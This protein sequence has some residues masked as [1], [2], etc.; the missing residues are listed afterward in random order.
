MRTYLP[1]ILLGGSLL[2]THLSAQIIGGD[3][4]ELHRF[5]G[6]ASNQLLGTQ[7][8]SAGDV[9]ADGVP[10]VILGANYSAPGGT[11][12]AG[13][14]FVYSGRNGVLLWRFDGTESAGWFGRSTAGV[15]DVDG[16]GF[17]DLLVGAP[18]ETPNGIARAGRA[19]LYSGATGALLR[20]FEGTNAFDYLGTSVAGA[21]DLDGD[22]I[23]DLIIGA[24][25]AH[26]GSGF[27]GSTFVYSGATGTLIWRFDGIQDGELMGSSVANAGDVDGDNVNDVIVGAKS[28]AH[29]GRSFAGAAYV[30]SGA[31]GMEIWRFNGKAAYDNFG[32][33][34]AG[35]GDVNGDGHDDLMIGIPNA[36]P[37]N[38]QYAG[39]AHVYSGATGEILWYFNGR[40]AG[41]Q[42]GDS[43]SG[44][45]D[46]N[47]DGFDDVIA[48]A[49]NVEGFAALGNAYVWS[50]ATGELLT[51][52]RGVAWGDNLG[53]AVALI[54][55]LNGDRLCDFAVGARTADPQDLNA[56][57]SVYV[58]SLQ[59]FL[60]TSADELSATNGTSVQLDLEFPTSQAGATYMVLASANGTGPSDYGKL[61]IPLTNDS[62]FLRMLGGWSPALLQNGSGTLDAQGNSTATLHGGSSLLTLVGKT[63]TLAAVTYDSATNFGSKSSIARHLKIVH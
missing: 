3:W 8:A 47:G 13:S 11:F 54:G 28:A 21:G 30:Y 23:G 27:T 4:K 40:S 35:A 15:G 19:Y 63:I 51:T 33:A 22:G 36:D 50:G 44:G 41:D 43:V 55:D 31:T 10:D 61:T 20:Q 1:L 56:A 48:G 32:S 2:N 18:K 12:Q 9:D 49:Q 62:L 25:N 24:T 60:H 42:L 39:A 7:V 37:N 52:I 46:V 59:P 29:H 45:G 17:G 16:D 34:V 6:T 38:L 26:P 57:G 58:H 53:S 14:A 5:D